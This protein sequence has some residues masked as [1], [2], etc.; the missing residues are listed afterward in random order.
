MRLISK[1]FRP[2]YS[3]LQITANAVSVE[4]GYCY[5]RIYKAANSTVVSNL[6][7]NEKKISIED[8]FEIQSVK[9][10]YFHK[11]TDLSNSELN[12]LF[13]FAIVR[14]PYDRFLSCY[15]DKIYKKDAVQRNKVCRFFKVPSDSDIP[16]EMFL[17]YLESGQLSSN[18]HWAPQYSFFYKEVNE[19]DYIGRV[20]NL[21]NDL[22]E[23]LN[24]IYGQQI[25][26][27]T[28]IESHAT[29]SLQQ[30][31]KLTEQQKIR[32]YSLYKDD[33]NFFNY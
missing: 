3:N 18:G 20:E 12:E 16:V 8:A 14:N 15:L 11:I 5:T 13:H 32:V 19:Y 25:E 31:F 28:T 21:N 1:L 30:E 9:D 10:S 7:R 26:D 2:K 4:Y 17:E 24:K 23:V 22:R 27:L 33:F 6:Y 29:K